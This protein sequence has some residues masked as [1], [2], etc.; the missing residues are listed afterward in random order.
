[1]VFLCVTLGGAAGAVARFALGGWIHSRRPG[2]PWGTLAINVSGAFALGFLL[3]T[4]A[5]QPLARALVTTGFLGAYTTFSSFGLETVALLDEGR[6]DRAVA[7]V[8]ATMAMG[9]PACFL[10]WWL[11]AG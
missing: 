7:Y 5:A 3:P 1:M 11:A 6:P 2:F 9:I 10:G 8:L 4:L